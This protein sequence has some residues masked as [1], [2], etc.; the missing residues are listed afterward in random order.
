M[1]T[2]LIVSVMLGRQYKST[3]DERW[4]E[5]VLR[6][7]TLDEKIGQLF[8]VAAYSNKD[9]EHIKKIEELI[10]NYHIGGLIFFQ[11]NPLKQAYLT[12]YY[13]E[14]SK[15]PLF[16]GIDAEWGLSMRIQPTVKYPYQLSLGSLQ[17][18][19]L[20]YEMGKQIGLQCKAMGIHINFA[21]V[22]DINNNPSNPIINFRSFGENR[23]QVARKS[24]AYASGMQDIGVMACAKHFPG[25]GDT[26]ADSH[27][28]LPS[29]L[30]KRNRLDSVELYPFKYLAERNIGAMMLAHLH[31]PALDSRANRPTSLSK[32][33]V[34]DLLK[35][36]YGFRGLAITDAL[37][38][39]GVRNNFPP[40]IGE[41]EAF[42]AGNHILL[43]PENI[44][45]AITKI[46]QALEE[47]TI[48]LQELNQRVL[49]ILKWKEWSGLGDY[50][51]INI[52]KLAS[53]LFPE[54]ADSLISKIAQESIVLLKDANGILPLRNGNPAIKNVFIIL[55]ND[56]PTAYVNEIKKSV[57]NPEIIFIKRGSTWETYQQQLRRVKA[58]N[59]YYVSIH[60]PKIW[61]TGSFGFQA[62][63]IKFMQHL[64]E[65]G[66][67]CNIFFCNPYIL[68][69]FNALKTIL[70]AH[71]D[72]ETFQLAA[73]SIVR[74]KTKSIGKMPVQVSDFKVG[75]GISLAGLFTNE[76]ASYLKKELIKIPATEVKV[77]VSSSLLHPDKRKQIDQIA[78]EIVTKKAAPG[79]RILVLQNGAVLYDKSQGFHTYN[80]QEPVKD[81]DL[82]DLASVTKVAATT[83]AV[84][85]LYEDG[86]LSLD[87]N[88]GKYLPWTRNS[89]KERISIRQILLHESGLP[90]WLP[91]YKETMGIL[92]DSLYSIRPDTN[93][94]V[95]VADRMYMQG[96]YRFVIYEK[97]LDAPLG[98]RKYLYSDLGMILMREVVEQASGEPFD[99]YLQKNFYEPMGLKSITFNPLCCFETTR[100]VP[101]ENDLK[102]RRQLIHGY[103]HDPC[104][105]MLGGYSGHA[106]LFATA[107]DLAAIGQ[108]LLNN[109]TYNQIQLLKPETIRLFTSKQSQKSR[110]GLGWDKPEFGSGPSPASKFASA[111][112]F[113]HTGFTGTGL[114]IDPEANL[115][116]VFLSNRIYPDEENRELIRGNYRTRIQD[117]LY[118]KP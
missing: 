5:H 90:A 18:D 47:G 15:H 67:S 45:L 114:W 76:E 13:Q 82:Y 38:M 109:G 86:K 20:I 50:K 57:N 87:D 40:G 29:I 39:K 25:H 97:I 116:Y 37:N 17:N 96:D 48:S 24:W 99:W 26:D 93:Y 35:N 65:T 81:N 103:V 102:Y 46:K 2:I 36:T 27:K 55:G 62:N 113:G 118:Q 91:F 98:A 104:A 85:K 94:C 72:G 107:Y 34:T 101:T 3:I 43:F 100:L 56:M 115:V 58:S 71:E 11:G 23:E 7:M 112:T 108:M 44:P 84:M 75:D 78:E 32:Y 53:D 59:H 77:V 63:E 30:H 8:M 6:G 42:L 89:N 83:L 60:E 21:P 61:N 28:E 41:L 70:V 73:L 88:L 33:V 68:K 9:V 54:N 105:A 110:R 51:P 66:K 4:Y 106:G 74:G 79:C 95:E 111:K 117:I 80:K 12:N 49:E 31:V 52:N 14:L 19:S 64:N 1:F 92:Y 69:K 10:S 22:A 16:I